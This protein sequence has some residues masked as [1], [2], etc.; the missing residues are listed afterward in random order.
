MRVGVDLELDQ[1][2]AAQLAAE[3][4]GPDGLTSVPVLEVLGTSVKP[5]IAPA[6]RAHRP[7]A[8]R[9]GNAAALR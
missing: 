5:S 9:D 6:A 2:T 8:G 3:L 4:R 1:G 7:P